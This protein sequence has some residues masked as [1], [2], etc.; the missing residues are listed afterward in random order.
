MKKGISK[1]QLDVSFI[2]NVCEGKFSCIFTVFSENNEKLQPVSLR[3]LTTIN[4]Y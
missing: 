3:L 4:D 2:L 1:I